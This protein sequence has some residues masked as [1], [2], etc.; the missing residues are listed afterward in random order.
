MRIVKAS[1]L[2]YYHMER[3]LAERTSVLPEDKKIRER[4]LR[5]NVQLSIETA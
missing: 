5:R 3:E 4:K 2:S 1:A